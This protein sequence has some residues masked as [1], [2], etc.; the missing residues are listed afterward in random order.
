MHFYNILTVGQ[1]SRKLSQLQQIK[2]IYIYH[3]Y[4]ISEPAIERHVD[5]QYSCHSDALPR[6]VV[7]SSKWLGRRLKISAVEE[8]KLRFLD[9][10]GFRLRDLASKFGCSTRT[11]ERRA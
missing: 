8:D 10:T 2:L 3:N 6:Q 7:R 5:I 4:R 11:V 9:E 1:F